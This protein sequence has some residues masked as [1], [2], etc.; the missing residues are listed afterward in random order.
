MIKDFTKNY[1]E[2]H[3]LK[4]KINDL[5]REVLFRPQEI[6]WCAIGTNIGVEVDGKNNFF[7]RP[8]LIFRKLNNE[9]FWGLPLTTRMRQKMLSHIE[10]TVHGKTQ[11]VILSQLRVLSTKRLIRRLTKISDHQFAI[12][13][14]SFVNYI[15]KTDPLRGPRVPN[16]NNET[17]VSKPNEKS[18]RNVDSS[19]QMKRAP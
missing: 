7:E 10:I 15:Y 11:F 13:N 16:G 19:P 9:M 8:V 1:A 4:S 14:E 5:D 18:T 2:W 3:T 6:W 17:I 12:I